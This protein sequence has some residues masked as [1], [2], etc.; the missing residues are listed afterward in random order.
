MNI[1][2][3]WSLGLFGKITVKTINHVSVWHYT[4]ESSPAYIFL[5]RL[6]IYYKISPII[7]G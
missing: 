1:Y 7:T 3:T 2:Y 6:E 4:I 5:D